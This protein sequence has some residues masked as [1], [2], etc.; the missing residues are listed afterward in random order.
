MKHWEKG[1]LELL[2]NSLEPIPQERNEI[3]WKS[4]LSENTEK[5]THHLSAFSNHSNGGFIVFGVNDK[6]GVHGIGEDASGEII[7]KL[8]N[9]A[10]DGLDPAIPVDHAIISFKG[11]NL[12]FVFIQ[13]SPQKPVH[14][15]G[16]TIHDSYLR[17]AGQTRRMSKQEVARCVAS[18]SSHPFEEEP[19]QEHLTDDEVIR[20][21][22]FMS[23]FDLQ[24]RDLPRTREE[25]LSLLEADRLIYAKGNRFDIT[26]LGALLFAKDLNEFHGL[27]RKTVRVILYDGKTRIK[28]IKEQPGKRGYASGFCGT[29]EICQR[30][31]SNERGYRTSPAEASE[32]VPRDRRQR[33]RCK[34]THSSGF[35][36]VWCWPYGR[37]LF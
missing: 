30:S 19:A 10:R 23:Y 26:N 28:T 31:A 8:G 37:N 7:K 25:I 13:E 12:L 15:R 21:L 11:I 34:R 6:G 29:N 18:S 14:V 27:Q 35:P 33:T 20:R 5:L 3:D 4:A 32:D 2:Q 24:K 9:I 17:S 36:D 16:K 22:D 1:A